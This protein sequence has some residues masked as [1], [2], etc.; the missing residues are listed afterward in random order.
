MTLASDNSP[1][2]SAGH[3]GSDETLVT[4][5]WSEALARNLGSSGRKLLGT[6]LELAATSVAPMQYAE[7]LA[8]L[9]QTACCWLLG[10]SAGVVWVELSP[11][12]ASVIADVLLGGNQESVTDRALTTIERHVLHRF[13]DTVAEAMEEPLGQKPGPADAQSPKLDPGEAVLVADFEVGLGDTQGLMRICL[14][15]KLGESASAPRP[16]PPQRDAHADPTPPPAGGAVE[17]SVVAAESAIPPDQLA[18]LR[19]GDVLITDTEAGKQ[20]VVRLNGKDAFV[21]QL[22]SRNGK[23]AVTIIGPLAENQ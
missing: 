1:H 22:G 16:A 6:S 13:V 12:I 11:E 8:S 18:A 14:P 15:A 9:E 3:H 2:R 20:L 17:L 5:P 19:P 4:Q 10:S 23:R 7:F 21:G